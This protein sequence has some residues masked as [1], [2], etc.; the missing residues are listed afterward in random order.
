[1]SAAMSSAQ[2][3]RRMWRRDRS[4]RAWPRA[5]G[6]TTR[7]SCAERVEGSE[8]VEAGAGHVAVEEEQRRRVLRAGHL[9]DEGGAPAVE[10]DP[11][12][13]RHRRPD[14][15]V[16]AHDRARHRVPDHELQQI[17]KQSVPCAPRTF[18]R[19]GHG[20]T[21]RGAPKPIARDFRRTGYRRVASNLGRP[22]PR[23]WSSRATDRPR[24]ATSPAPTAARD[25]ASW[26][27]RSGGASSP[28]IKE[29]ADRLAAGGFTALCPDL[30]H[31]ELAEHT[32]MDQAA[33]ADDRDAARPRRPRH[34][35][36]DRLP[37]RRRRHHRR[38]HR[39]RRLLHGRDAGVAHRRATAPTRC[40]A[41]VPFYGYP[42]GDMEPD[43]SRLDAPVRGHM[44]EHD[45]FFGPDGARALEAKL[46]GPGQGRARSR[47]TRA[48][49]TRSWRRTT[50]SARATRPKADEIWPGV[51]AFLHEQLG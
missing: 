2:S 5:S 27:S 48:P 46:Q 6:A 42:S 29:M 33:A 10:L 30:Y 35:R 47:C 45:D 44:A 9:A 40:G 17:A 26:W 41:V 50:R 28:A 7:K 20:A 36:R 31:G 16:V 24:G 14:A 23:W 25:R 15:A 49:A 51:L 12:A 4:P 37:A 39:R 34:E 11:A 43:W 32:E 22:W 21:D 19:R 1:M 18:T 3:A 38:R 13:E 8:P